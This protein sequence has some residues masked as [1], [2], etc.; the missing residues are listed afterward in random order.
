[1]RKQNNSQK[2]FD[3]NPYIQENMNDMQRDGMNQGRGSINNL[4]YQNN[5]ANPYYD[6]NNRAQISDSNSILN[7]FDTGNFVKGALI[8]AVGAYLLTNKDAQKTIFKT[9]AKGTEMFQAGIEEM[10][11]R[12]EDAKAEMQAGN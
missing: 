12:F 10:K 3:R 7:S 9:V 4:G 8:G 11:E 5:G 1:M 6:T 2:G